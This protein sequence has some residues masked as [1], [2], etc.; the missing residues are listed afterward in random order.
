VGSLGFG[1]RHHLRR[2]SSEA[3]SQVAGAAVAARRPPRHTLPL[4]TSTNRPPPHPIP[5]KNKGSFTETELGTINFPEITTPILEKIC[6]Y[7]YYK[8]RYQ[9]S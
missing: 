1:Q 5:S 7:F 4:H 8:L 3:Q 9:N 2:S 6:Q